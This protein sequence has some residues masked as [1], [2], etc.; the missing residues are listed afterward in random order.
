MA[1]VSKLYIKMSKHIKVAEKEGKT[2]KK[3]TLEEV[4]TADGT[5]RAE[6]DGVHGVLCSQELGS[7][8]G[9]ISC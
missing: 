3:D 6:R 9:E 7:G 2:R 1:E 5:L 8:V 4:S